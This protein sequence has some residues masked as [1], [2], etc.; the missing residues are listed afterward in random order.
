MRTSYEVTLRGLTFH[1]RVGVLPHERELAQPIEIDVTAW[2]SVRASEAP[3]GAL[4]D[5]RVLYDSVASVMARGP[6]D[7]LEGLVASIANR[8][9]EDAVVERVRVVAR[10]PHVVLPGP[11]AGAEVALELA[12]DA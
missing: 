4:L 6:A 3:A 11:L 8:V 9:L 1:T 7:Y 12:R 2:P 5:Y 10:K